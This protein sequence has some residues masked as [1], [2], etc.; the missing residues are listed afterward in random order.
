MEPMR[1]PPPPPYPPTPIHDP[2]PFRT[3]LHEDEL[4]MS[5]MADFF[6]IMFLTMFTHLLVF[7]GWQALLYKK[8]A[9]LRLKKGIILTVRDARG[10]KVIDWAKK[11]LQFLRSFSPPP[12]PPPSPA[13]S[14][15]PLPPPPLRPLPPP[16]PPRLSARASL[17]PLSGAAPLKPLA[18]LSVTVDTDLLRVAGTD[19]FLA[20][21]SRLTPSAQVLPSSGRFDAAG[22]PTPILR[23][24]VSASPRSLPSLSDS[25]RGV[26]ISARSFGPASSATSSARASSKWPPDPPRADDGLSLACS[27]PSPGAD[28]QQRLSTGLSTGLSSS[29]QTMAEPPSP[30][31]LESL[32]SSASSKE[33][34]DWK[35]L[36]KTSYASGFAYVPAMVWWPHIEVIIVALYAP[37]IMMRSASTLMKP[38]GAELVLEDY[39]D[40]DATDAAFFFCLCLLCFFVHEGARLAV[41]AHKFAI[42]L[43]IETP[44][45]KSRKDMDDP[46]LRTL[47]N[48]CLWKPAPRLRGVFVLEDEHDDWDEPE[49]SARAVKIPYTYAFWKRSI[50]DAYATLA[51][52]WLIGAC[53]HNPTPTGLRWREVGY[54][55]PK[56]SREW[57]D[58]VLAGA[59]GNSLKLSKKEW[60]SIGIKDLKLTDCVSVGTPKVYYQ[61]REEYPYGIFCMYIKVLF[62]VVYAMLVGFAEHQ[63]ANQVFILFTIVGMQLLFAV[64]C[65]RTR[66][67][68]DRVEAIFV[69][70]EAVL[71][72][73]GLFVLVVAAS[74]KSSK[75][76]YLDYVSASAWLTYSVI[77][78]PL[79]LPVYHGYAAYHRYKKRTVE[80]KAKA[81]RRAEYRAKQEAAQYREPATEEEMQAATKITS[82]AKGSA[83]RK[84]AAGKK[85][86]LSKQKETSATK[87]SARARGNKG[88]RIAAEMKLDI[89]LS[90]EDEE[91]SVSA[92]KIQ[93]RTRG[94]RARNDV[95]HQLS[96]ILSIQS[97][98]RGQAARRQ[99]GEEYDE[100]YARRQKRRLENFQMRRAVRII[101]RRIGDFYRRAAERARARREEREKVAATQ[102]ERVMRGH[103]LRIRLRQKIRRERQEADLKLLNSKLDAMSEATNALDANRMAA[104]ARRQEKRNA[105]LNAAIR[106][107]SLARGNIARRKDRA[108]KLGVERPEW[109]ISLPKAAL[110]PPEEP[111]PEPVVEEARPFSVHW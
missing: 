22:A 2:D 38:R 93:A 99:F 88:R 87:I 53:G 63:S 85:D 102:I 11:G 40:D 19:S 76:P 90:K 79:L 17:P 67:C 33:P 73:T 10:Q 29:G 83:T 1:P 7:R 52:S 103:L 28:R 56:G 25:P 68:A 5:V 84:K 32:S 92:Q 30:S 24:S 45:I 97:I 14:P 62:Q 105:Q 46:L 98:E 86:A 66:L 4:L 54:R 39:V 111:S 3:P 81:K 50:G 69:S 61:P 107:N 74:E 18:P 65:W 49:R 36:M 58:P 27:G 94:R 48:Y 64:L 82:V 31:S 21:Q 55:K 95:D 8:N 23:A 34:I 16:P 59:V 43:W 71:S 47:V 44:A 106:I 110:P 60:K 75:R 100:R 72:A 51:R 70:L 57:K 35:A 37:C 101:R 20:M 26:T 6:F 91:R 41:F 109:Q 80:L 78:V 77:L 42:D 96:S 104:K 13:P 15:P 108:R 9:R 12:S 89:E